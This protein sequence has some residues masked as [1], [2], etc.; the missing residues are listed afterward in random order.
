MLC[1]LIPWNPSHLDAEDFD[2]WLPTLESGHEC[3]TRQSLGH[4]AL[5]KKVMSSCVVL[6][7]TCQTVATSELWHIDGTD[8]GQA[9]IARHTKACCRR[10][11]S[12][13]QLLPPTPGLP[14][15]WLQSSRLHQ[16]LAARFTDPGAIGAFATSPQVE[17]SFLPLKFLSF[18]YC[19][20]S[21]P[22]VLRGPPPRKT[23]NKTP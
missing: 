2:L 21:S 13:S 3:K 4:P 22:Y 20:M 12:S 18:Q 15:A 1:P 9:P 5:Q 23:E 8:S 6:L 14:P 19:Y 16:H 11:S 10:I 17:N 7:E